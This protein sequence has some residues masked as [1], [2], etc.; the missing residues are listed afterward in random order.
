[1]RCPVC[2]AENTTGPQCRR[3]RADLSLLFA[4]EDQRVHL[5]VA[6]RAAIRRAEAG[7]A[8]RLAEGAQQL[9]DGDDVRRL[10]ALG[11]L[12]RRDFARAWQ[13]LASALPAP[14]PQG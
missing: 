2:R 10:L 14:S 11:H 5:L 4:L 9:R 13:S 7:E 3:C 12:L 6:A 8:V 1:M